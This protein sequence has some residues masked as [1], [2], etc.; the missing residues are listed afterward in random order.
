MQDKA[1]EKPSYTAPS[2]TVIGPLATLTQYRIKKFGASDGVT[3]L[4]QPIGNASV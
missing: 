4:G 2:I 3:Y 1:Q